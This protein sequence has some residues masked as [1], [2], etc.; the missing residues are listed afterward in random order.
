MS[1]N[2]EN[3]A[4]IRCNPCPHCVFCGARGTFIYKKLV[5]RIFGAPGEWNLKKC[6]DKECGVIW[7][8]PQPLSEDIVKAYQSYYTHNNS[9]KINKTAQKRFYYYI[10]KKYWAYQYGYFNGSHSLWEKI[11][12]LAI[13]LHPLKQASLDLKVMYLP[14]KFNP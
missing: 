8:D 11:I 6:V 3:I 9:D 13:S 10:K 5:D 2:R 12:G 4:D 1:H 7:L 14:A